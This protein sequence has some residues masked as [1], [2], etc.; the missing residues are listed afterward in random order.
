MTSIDYKKLILVL[1]TYALIVSSILVLSM[2]PLSI[3]EKEI[4]PG[5]T[6]DDIYKFLSLFGLSISVV[7]F[8][9]VLRIKKRE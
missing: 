7:T 1:S 2:Q 9:L 6:R 3:F 5:V 8:V 4:V